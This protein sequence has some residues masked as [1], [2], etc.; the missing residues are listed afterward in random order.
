MSKKY[1]DQKDKM[2]PK[3]LAPS[4]PPQETKSADPFAS[5]AIEKS[6]SASEKRIWLILPGIA[7]IAA[8]LFARGIAPLLIASGATWIAMVLFV[9]ARSEFNRDNLDVDPLARLY[10]AT[11]AAAGVSVGTYLFLLVAS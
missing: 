2:D 9:I 3:N 11:A 8:G 7:V 6:A 1:K 4:N 10:M 5:A